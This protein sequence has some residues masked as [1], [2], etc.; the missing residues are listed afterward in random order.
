VTAGPTI[1]RRR[2]WKVSGP[3]GR[4]NDVFEARVVMPKDVDPDDLRT[5]D[6]DYELWY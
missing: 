6:P 5:S 3:S 1:G 2:L 4:A